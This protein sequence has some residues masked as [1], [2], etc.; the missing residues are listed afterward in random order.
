[1]ARKSALEAMTPERRAELYEALARGNTRRAVFEAYGLTLRT[2]QD[3]LKWGRDYRLEVEEGR[4]PNPKHAMFAEF[5]EHVERSEG[6]A[7]AALTDSMFKAA[8]GERRTKI[9]IFAHSLSPC[10]SGLEQCLSLNR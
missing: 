8:V 7:E 5:L 2:A 9:R 6:Q 10:S 4:E 3:Y 1:M